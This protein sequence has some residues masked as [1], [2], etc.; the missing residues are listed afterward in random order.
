MR[1]PVTRSLQTVAIVLMA[2]AQL[3][4]IW[5]TRSSSTS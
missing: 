3:I 4:V 5:R 2:V 1:D